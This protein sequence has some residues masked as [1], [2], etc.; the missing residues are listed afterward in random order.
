MTIVK[1]KWIKITLTES[2][3]DFSESL[4][5]DTYN[6]NKGYGFDLFEITNHGFNGE[7]IEKTTHDEKIISPDGIESIVSFDRYV[8]FN[9]T[10]YISKNDISYIKVVNPP[11]SLKKFI[12][13]LSTATSGRLFIISD[14]LKV[15]SI[16]S[17]FES[18]L[19]VNKFE[20]KKIF[21]SNLRIT[22]NGVSKIEI[23]SDKN[24]M[25][26][27][28]QA[29]EGKMY[30]LNRIKISFVINDFS[31]SIEFSR[32]GMVSIDDSVYQII[33]DDLSKLVMNSF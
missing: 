2:V 32:T 6:D 29:F 20:V 13:N 26:D 10:F 16:Y 1:N 23:S 4:L 11:V 31:G 27:F 15:D 30:K 5:S 25:D 21:I 17:N 3:S 28:F 24:A 14:E 12:N 7:Y 22:K 19:S 9:F 8:K 33:E 18:S